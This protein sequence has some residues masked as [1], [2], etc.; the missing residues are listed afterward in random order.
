MTFKSCREEISLAVKIYT[1][2]AVGKVLLICVLIS[3]IM[4][5]RPKVINLCDSLPCILPVFVG[6]AI[7][8]F[9]VVEMAGSSFLDTAVR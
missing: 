8:K 3:I 7:L 1:G 2:Q 9:V 4:V 5:S 6:K